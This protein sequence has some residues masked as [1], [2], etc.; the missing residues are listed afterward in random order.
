MAAGGKAVQRADCTQQF[1]PGP[2]ALRLQHTLGQLTDTLSLSLLICKMG[3][4]MII[5]DMT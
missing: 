2:T 4:N 3:I 1:W 5:T